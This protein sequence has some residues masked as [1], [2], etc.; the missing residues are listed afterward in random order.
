MLVGSSSYYNRKPC[1]CDGGRSAKT[2]TPG[3]APSTRWYD[4]AGMLLRPYTEGCGVIV[5]GV[6]LDHNSSYRRGT[7]FGPPAIRSALLCGSVNW[8][9][10]SGLDL[11]G[12]PRWGDAGDLELA[13]DAGDM[14]RI[15]RACAH[16]LDGGARILTL[17]GDHSITAPV[18]R[19]VHAAHGP[20]SIVHFDAHP[21]LY[22]DFE[23]NR[24]SHASPFH[25]IME[26]GLA[27]RLVQIGIRTLNDV[28]HEA[29]DRFS[30]E[31]LGPDAVDRWSGLETTDPVYVSIDLDVLDPAFAP[32]VSHFEPGGLSVRQVLGAL[33]RIRAPLV[34]ADIVEL[35]PEADPSGRTGAVGAKFAKELLAGLLA[36]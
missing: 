1:A 19:A 25:R 31:V 24:D 9:S 8:A 11:T 10:E 23:G 27:S 33:K 17:G 7:R 15:Q 30:V 3:S 20:V 29:V 14:Q 21:D 36:S 34:G 13:G 35:N 4:H 2:S 22:P 18:L 16:H 6:P 26:E 32:G 12:D 28:Q 5:Q